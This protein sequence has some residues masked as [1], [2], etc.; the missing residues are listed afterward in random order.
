ML[1]RILGWE[2]SACK[3]HCSQGSQ[4]FFPQRRT[5]T[6]QL[7]NQLTSKMWITIFQ[8]IRDRKDDFGV[9]W[10]AVANIKVRGEISSQLMSGSSQSEE[11]SFKTLSWPWRESILGVSSRAEHTKSSP[12]PQVLCLS[13]CLL[14]LGAVSPRVKVKLCFQWKVQ[15][16]FCSLGQRKQ[17]QASGQVQAVPL[18]YK[19]YC[20]H[21]PSCF[22]LYSLQVV[23]WV[24]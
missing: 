5:C 18:S 16:F 17:Y 1:T 15:F 13:H 9:C 22:V 11:M 24:A 10:L 21:L 20:L 14:V 3:Y 8:N 19:C 6:N 23:L 12:H 4:G 7:A 2:A